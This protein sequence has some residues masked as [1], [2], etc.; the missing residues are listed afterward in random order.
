MKR[1]IDKYEPCWCGSGRKFIHCH[2]GIDAAPNEQKVLAS[3]AQYCE[4]WKQ[5]SAEIERQNGYRWMA[6]Q[7]QPYHPKRILDIGCGLGQGVLALARTFDQCSIITLDENPVTLKIAYELA[8]RSGLKSLY[9]ER[10]SVNDDAQNDGYYLT[11]T[12]EEVQTTCEGI[13]FIES[14]FLSDIS[15]MK[16]LA[17]GPQFDAVTLWLIGTHLL[18]GKCLNL[19]NVK[20]QT[21]QDYRLYLQNRTYEFADNV[22]KRGGVLH[23]VDRGESPAEESLR[24]CLME[25]HREQAEPTSLQVKELRDFP[26]RET[27]KRGAVPMIHSLGL[28]GRKPE[29]GTALISIIS[30]K[31]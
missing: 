17:E 29:Y 4:A 31:P 10:I 3:Y 1:R 20:L 11:H 15:G 23:I 6:A 25:A 13:H 19:Q 2:S 21:S 26:Y 14:D 18:K 12:L 27:D 24:Q 9:T 28:S 7:L 16:W 30:E 5:N 22:L 8:V